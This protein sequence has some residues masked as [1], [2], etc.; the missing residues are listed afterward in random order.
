MT[1]HLSMCAVMTMASVCGNET[2]LLSAAV[3]VIGI[4]EHMVLMTGPGDNSLA[5][6]SC[7][8][9]QDWSLR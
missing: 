1:S 4:W 2:S 8:E 7:F 5:S 6:T 3:K 9:N